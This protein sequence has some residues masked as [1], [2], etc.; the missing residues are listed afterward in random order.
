[1]MRN[2]LLTFNFSEMRVGMKSSGIGD[3]GK[4]RS[5]VELLQPLRKI[6]ASERPLPAKDFLMMGIEQQDGEQK[7][8][9]TNFKPKH[10]QTQGHK[11]HDKLIDH[12]S[13]SSSSLS[14]SPFTL[15]SVHPMH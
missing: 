9:C 1:M 10:Q 13:F 3:E 6:R 8:N 2:V 12:C 11:T 5:K 7:I 4:A 14:K 15:I